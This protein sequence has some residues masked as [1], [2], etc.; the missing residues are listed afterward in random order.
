VGK[1]NFLHLYPLTF[2]EFLSALGQ[3]KLLSF[4]HEHPS[5]QPLPL[6]LHETLMHLLKTYFFVGGMPE[7]V[8]EYAKNEKLHV[9]REIQLEIL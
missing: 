5:H 7:V 2:F 3:D 6:P 4:L 1:V 9:A 8:A